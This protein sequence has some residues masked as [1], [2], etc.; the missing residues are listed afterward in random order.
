MR[1]SRVS[2]ASAVVD[3]PLA[4]RARASAT[5]SAATISFADLLDTAP[6][7]RHSLLR[8]TLMQLH[9]VILT[10]LKSTPKGRAGSFVKLQDNGI[11]PI[12]APRTNLARIA[13]AT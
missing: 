9:S 4:D 1:C 11:K 13:A 2:E 10:D 12:E 3:L 8:G 7:N 5:R 6:I